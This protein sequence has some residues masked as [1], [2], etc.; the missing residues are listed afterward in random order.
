MNSKVIP[1]RPAPAI[2]HSGLQFGIYPGGVSGAWNELATG[3]PD[4]PDEINRALD[5]LQGNRPFLVRNYLRFNGNPEEANPNS[6]PPVADLAQYTWN[7]R[8]LD[9][10][11]CHWDTRGNLGGWTQFIQNAVARYGPY[12][13]SFQICEEPNLYDYPGDGRFPQAVEAILTGVPAARQKLRQMGLDAAVG[14]NAVPCSDPNDGFW[15]SI[16]KKITTD[17]V[18]SLDYV[19]LNF[20]PDVTEPMVGELPEVVTDVLTEFR[21]ENLTRAGIPASVPIHISENGWPTGP[22][23]YYTRQA[24]LLEQMIRTVH[25]LRRQLNITHYQLFALRDADTGNPDVFRQFGIM[26]DDYSPKPAFEIYRRL[27]AEFG[28]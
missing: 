27:I 17:F 18:H 23:R 22:Y 15:R 2:S 14:F 3:K 9:L 28:G 10:A 24:E 25:G 20:Y 19:G 5:L 16:A 21:K 26:R 7:G 6:L 13:R 8:K 1:F 11:L 12:V 4:R